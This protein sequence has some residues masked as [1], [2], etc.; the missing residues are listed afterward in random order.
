[1][2]KEAKKNV[3]QNKVLKVPI[4]NK[5]QIK[6]SKDEISKKLK[7]VSDEV[8]SKVNL[9][10]QK[11]DDTDPATKKKIVAGVSAAAAVLVLLAGIGKHKGKK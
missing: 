3:K 8:V 9:L 2:P 4:E 11:F 7:K 10:K 6:I 5:D 1:M